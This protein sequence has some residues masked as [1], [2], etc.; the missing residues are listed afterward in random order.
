MPNKHIQD[1]AEVSLFATIVIWKLTLIGQLQRTVSPLTHS[2]L[3]EIAFMLDRAFTMKQQS[4][5][6]KSS[7]DEA[8]LRS[9]GL[10]S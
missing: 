3:Y 2:E 10:L 8:S 9:L 7:C 4:A 1:S 6:L 5:I